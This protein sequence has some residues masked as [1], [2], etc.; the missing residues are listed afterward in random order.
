MQ[1]RSLPIL[2]WGEHQK[3]QFP[4]CF[5]DQPQKG[6]NF[7]IQIKAKVPKADLL[8]VP[9]Q[10]NPLGQDWLP[11][12][13]AVDVHLA[14]QDRPRA[15]HVHINHRQLV[16]FRGILDHDHVVAHLG[17]PQ[18]QMQLHLSESPSTWT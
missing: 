8:I 5:Q 12:L 2:H 13:A 10:R 14:F 7:P 17:D 6:N 15:L 1:Q 3:A 16:Y 11:V 4:A 18:L 9:E